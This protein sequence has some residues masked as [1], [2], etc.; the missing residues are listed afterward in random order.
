MNPWTVLSLL[1][2]L[3]QPDKASKPGSAAGAAIAVLWHP[4]QVGGEEG[5]S[6]VM[7]VGRWPEVPVGVTQ[8][9]CLS[10]L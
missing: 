10:F 5:M 9:R 3:A 2:S 7:A 6:R 1:C 8:L 4:R